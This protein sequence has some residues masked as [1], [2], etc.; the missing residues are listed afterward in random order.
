MALLACCAAVQG[1]GR[2]ALRMGVHWS[3]DL[4]GGVSRGSWRQAQ[5]AV[6][7]IALVGGRC[8]P[9]A[10]RAVS[11][12]QLVFLVQSCQLSLPLQLLLASL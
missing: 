11:L 8:V 10:Q 6:M 12:S 1:G 9:A 7:L 2:S 3:C 4:T 5:L